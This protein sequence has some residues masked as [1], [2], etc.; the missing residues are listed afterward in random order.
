M[1]T[2]TQLS[3]EKWETF[4]V[5]KYSLGMRCLSNSTIATAISKNLQI[6]IFSDEQHSDCAI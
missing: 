1:N 5:C 3:C 6:S 4:T 2:M